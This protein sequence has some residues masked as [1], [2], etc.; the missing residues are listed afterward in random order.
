MTKRYPLFFLILLFLILQSCGGGGG[1]ASNEGS[2]TGLSGRLFLPA[3]RELD[4]ATGKNVTTLSNE[5]KNAL[6]G[7]KY[8]DFDIYPNKDG[9][10][11]LVEDRGCYYFYLQIGIYG[12]LEDCVYI[13][14]SKGEKVLHSF[15]KY[16]S[17]SVV[18]LSPDGQTIAAVWNEGEMSLGEKRVFLFS[19]DGDWLNRS[20]AGINEVAWLP[21]GRLVV[22]SED[23]KNII[24]TN[25]PNSFKSKIIRHFE[26]SVGNLSVSPDGKQLAFVMAGFLYQ[27]IWLM[28][29]DGTN[30]RQLTKNSDKKE[31]TFDHPVWSPD[32]KWVMC[33]KDYVRTSAVI[34][35]DDPTG[36]SIVLGT[37][38]GL[39]AVR[40]DVGTLDF[41]K[42]LDPSVVHKMRN[43]YGAPL[44]WRPAHAGRKGVARLSLEGSSAGQWRSACQ[45]VNTHTTERFVR[46]Q[47]LITATTLT[48]QREAYRDSLCTN[49]LGLIP[50]PQ[51]YNLGAALT[52]RSGLRATRLIP[53]PGHSSETNRL[54]YLDSSGT[55]YLGRGDSLDFDIAYARY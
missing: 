47:L 50:E 52:T 25:Q 41:S 43:G 28:N 17:L 18:T 31:H 10:R 13:T 34:V 48:L 29:I 54:L 20:S 21:D 42:P 15:W 55:V 8:T 44:A 4:I 35:P 5:A 27:N 23:E 46:Q 12:H 19:L 24:V 32:G 1:D 11:L 45:H 3:G 30:L 53:D 22:V 49:R 38:G 40:T 51:Q 16:E 26:Y 33:R 7:G 39:Y 2:V 6:V 37:L 14:D 9:S 36:D